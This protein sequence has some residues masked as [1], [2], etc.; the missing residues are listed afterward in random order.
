MLRKFLVDVSYIT[1]IYSKWAKRY[2][3]HFISV[4]I[5]LPI[6]TF[7]AL[8][9]T[10]SPENKLYAI[11]G[12]MVFAISISTILYVAQWVGGDKSLHRLSLFATL[13]VSP[14]AYGFGVALSAAIN[15]LIS[16]SSILILAS[17]FYGLTLSWGW[18]LLVPTL[19]VSF[20]AGG[21][22]GLLIAWSTKDPRALSATAQLVTFAFGLFAPVFYPLSLLPVPLR[23]VAQ[24]IPTTWSAALVRDSL[25]GNMG[26]YMSDF[27]PLLAIAVILFLLVVKT[28]EWRQK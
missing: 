15:N 18:L 14:I 13:P 11:S 27:I 1:L 23:L 26:S 3:I 5:L 4:P 17:M 19:L 16:I 25:T 8:A 21:S 12:P 6:G 10:I 22:I 20:V 7:V 28:V 2:P 24:A 9:F